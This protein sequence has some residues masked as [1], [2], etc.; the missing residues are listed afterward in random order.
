MIS[1]LPWPFLAHFPF[2]SCS[3]LMQNSIVAASPYIVVICHSTVVQNWCQTDILVALPLPVVISSSI[4]IQKKN[5]V[6]FWLPYT[7]LWSFLVQ[8]LFRIDAKWIPCCLAPSCAYFPFSS[9]SKL[10]QNGIMAALPSLVVICHSTVA[11]NWWQTLVIQ[12]LFKIDAKWFPGCLASSC[13]H[14]L[15]K[16]YSKLMQNGFLAALPFTVVISSFLIQLL[17]QIDAKWFPCCL[18]L[19]CAH[20]PLISR[21]KLMVICF[22]ILIQTWCKRASWLPTPSCGHFLFNLYSKLMRN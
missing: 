9:C 12:S 20:F 8:F 15:F 2:S 16:S 4:L 11:Q 10:M 3:K 17:P 18:A 22:S 21:S 5:K 6:A 14:I 1:L 13:G 7:F 19:P